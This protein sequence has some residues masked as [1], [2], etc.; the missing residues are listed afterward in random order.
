MIK[1]LI[2]QPFRLIHTMPR[3]LMPCK[4][5]EDW[6]AVEYL[7]EARNNSS[8]RHD[9]ELGMSQ[10]AIKMKENCHTKELSNL[11]KIIDDYEVELCITRDLLAKLHHNVELNDR[12]LE[13]L[14]MELEKYMVHRESELKEYIKDQHDQ[15][16]NLESKRDKIIN[17][18]GICSKE[19]FNN[20]RHV[21][22]KI[23]ELKKIDKNDI[24]FMDRYFGFEKIINSK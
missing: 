6:E 10:D 13:L 15:L 1:Q 12:E 3:I 4:W 20:I 23:N 7:R 8:V 21:E 18:G 9:Q 24:R 11:Q 22:N 17:L 5:C 19:I 16:Y 2:R 14:H